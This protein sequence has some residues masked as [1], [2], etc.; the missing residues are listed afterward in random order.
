MLSKPTD[1]VKEILARHY[2][3]SRHWELGAG[4]LTVRTFG[5]LQHTVPSACFNS[6]KLIRESWAMGKKG[7]FIWGEGKQRAKGSRR[8]PD[9]VSPS[10]HKEA[11]VCPALTFPLLSLSFPRSSLFP[12][13]FSETERK[14]NLFF[15]TFTFLYFKPP[16]IG[17]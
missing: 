6:Y 14:L 5:N 1:F 12:Q 13:S 4:H 2:V 10:T 3:K 9:R 7:H 11:S 17:A 8:S 16:G 15:S